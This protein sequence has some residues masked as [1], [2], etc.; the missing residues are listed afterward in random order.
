MKLLRGRKS[1]SYTDFGPPYAVLNL[2]KIGIHYFRMMIKTP[3]NNG[4]R[5]TLLESY[6]KHPNTGWIFS[7]KGWFNI[8][9]GVWAHDNN[10]INEL[11]VALRR[12][13]GPRDSLVHQSELT[14]LYSFGHQPVAGEKAKP[15]PIVDSALG[16]RQL[17][18]LELDYIKLV[19]LDD[20]LGHQEIA[21]IL[22]TSVKTIEKMRAD[23]EDQG[24]IVGRQRRINY[25]GYYYKV[26]IDTSSAKY[27]GADDELARRVWNDTDC[28][29]FE[30]ANSKYNLE[31]ELILKKRRYIKKYVKDFSDYKLATLDNNLYTNLYPLSKVANMLEIRE[32]LMSQIGKPATDLRQS[33]IWYLNYR[34]ADAYLNIYSNKRYFEVMEKSELDLFSE[35]A[36]YLKTEKNNHKYNIVDIGSGNGLKAQYFINELGDKSVKAYYAVDVQ[37]IELAAAL[38]AHEGSSYG[39]H[40]VLLDFANLGARFPLKTLP[41]ES[42][43]YLF[44]GGTYG[45]FPGSVINGYLKCLLDEPNSRLFITMPIHKKQ[46][47][48]EDLISMYLTKEI[49]DLAFGPLLQAG[50]SKNDFLDNPVKKG[51]KVMISIEDKRLV[52]SFTLAK[53]K[54]LLERMFKKDSIF[55][56]TTSWKPTLNEFRDSLETDFKVEKIFSNSSMAIAEVAK[57]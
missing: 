48:E 8:A 19:T 44:L 38:R 5:K 21:K 18:H 37:P 56:M 3:K 27:P 10:E 1:N 33:K 17:S 34:A 22:S 55:K 46:L 15:M 36:D 42:Q 25:P 41:G 30:R 13:L 47:N 57:K 6:I 50:F 28:I 29:Y 51:L 16:H 45:N 4:L 32:I 53:N 12:L 7:G 24:I 35:I 2:S 9:V 20:S 43:L 54:K 26:F 39:L 23:F 40:P 52:S 31:F 14:S 49:E 11:G